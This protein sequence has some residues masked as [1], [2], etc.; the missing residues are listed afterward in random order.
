MSGKCSTYGQLGTDAARWMLSSG[1]KCGDK[2][3]DPA[4]AIAEIR[5]H[6]VTLIGL[7]EIPHPLLGSGTNLLC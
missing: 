5:R 3:A 4:S 6:S 2:K 7:F 1:R